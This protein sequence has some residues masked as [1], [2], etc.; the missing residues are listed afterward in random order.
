MIS[1]GVL[2]LCIPYP[3]ADCHTV[4]RGF[5]VILIPN[6]YVELLISGFSSA[7]QRT[8]ASF[9]HSTDAKTEVQN[10][11]V[12]ISQQTSSRAQNR[13]EISGGLSSVHYPLGYTVPPF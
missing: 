1:L 9:P 3:V 2:S 7:L 5:C 8:S 4:Q 10:G 6:S 11:G 12:K 13:S